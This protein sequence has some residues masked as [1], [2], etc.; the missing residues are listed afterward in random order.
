MRRDRGQG[1]YLGTPSS[2]P[3]THLNERFKRATNRP[4]TTKI[5]EENQRTEEKDQ[6][7]FAP[8]TMDRSE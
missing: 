1:Q 4:T 5:K 6:R 2:R 8:I 7:R 3:R